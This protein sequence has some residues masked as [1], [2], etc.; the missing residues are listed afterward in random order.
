ME[1]IYNV[2]EKDENNDEEFIEEVSTT[3][4]KQTYQKAWLVEE[5]ARLQELLS[6][7]KK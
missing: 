7:F 2:I 1:K 5:I 3:E 4:S 6:K